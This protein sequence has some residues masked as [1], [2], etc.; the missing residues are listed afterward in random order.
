MPTNSFS[1]RAVDVILARLKRLFLPLHDLGP[2][3][4]QSGPQDPAFS[5][6]RQAHPVSHR[7]GGARPSRTVPPLSQPD[8]SIRA[9]YGC[10][11]GR[12]SRCEMGPGGYPNAVLTVPAPHAKGGR[13]RHIH[14]NAVALSLLKE[15]PRSLNREAYVFGTGT[16]QLPATFERHWRQALSQAELKDFHFHDLRHTYASRLVMAGVDLAV[17]RE[18]LGHSDF[19]MTLRY[20]HLQ[21]S[22][23][24]EA[25]RRP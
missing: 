14:L 12:N 25:C 18:L 19:T 15:L 9:P 22:R 5:G 3:R 23:L 11:E 17:L 16:C 13:D 4:F 8:R 20:A 21:P 1:K 7:G 6:G 2:L 24:Q 10:E